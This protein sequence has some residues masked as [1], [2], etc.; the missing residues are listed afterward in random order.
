[1]DD[2]MKNILNALMVVT[3]ALIGVIL[4]TLIIMLPAIIQL[5]NKIS[6][7]P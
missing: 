1:M 4:F 6:S 5:V 2:R 3:I 7:I